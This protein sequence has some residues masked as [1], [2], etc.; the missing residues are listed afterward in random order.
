MRVRRGSR[1]LL[2]FV[3]LITIVADIGF[4]WAGWT[5]KHIF[6]PDWHPHARFHAAQLMFLVIAMSLAGLWLVW[7]RSREPRV[8]VTVVGFSMATYWIGEFFAFLV[9]G[10]SPSPDIENPNTFSVAGLDVYGNLFFAALMVTVSALAFV[11]GT[12]GA[13]ST[14]E[15]STRERTDAHR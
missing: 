11:L 7:R 15:P 4:V 12:V 9:P 2:S 6:N 14:A 10:T 13:R 8:A 3:L 1:L 5:G